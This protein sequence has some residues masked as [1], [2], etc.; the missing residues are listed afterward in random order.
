MRRVKALALCLAGAWFTAAPAPSARAQDCAVP[1]VDTTSGAVCGIAAAAA[2]RVR[3]Y[4]GIP[5]GQSTAG[6]NRWAPPRTVK[7]SSATLDA[8]T[9]GPICPQAQAQAGG[10]PMSEDCLSLN[11]WSPAAG[12]GDKLPVMVFLHGG[13][14]VIGSSRNPLYQAGKLAAHGQVV[15]VSLNYRLGALGFLA[16]LE[17]LAGNYGLL[18]QR[19]AL[20]WVRDNIAGFG[21]D[22][23]KVTLFGESAGA[24]SV[25]LH[26]ISPESAPLFRAAIMESNPYGIPYKTPKQAERLAVL[27]RDSLACE[28]GGI[29]CMRTRPFKAIVANQKSAL[30]KLQGVLSGL[31]GFLHWAPVLD[32]TL[33]PAQPAASPIAK[34]AIIGTNRDE[35]VLFATATGAKSL[36]KLE[37]ELALTLLFP[38]KAVREIK[39]LGRYKPARGDNTQALARLI[40]DFLFTCPSRRVMAQADSPVFGYQ[41]AQVPSYDM[42][43]QIPLCAPDQAKVCHAFELPFVFGNATTIVEQPQPAAHEFTP[44]EQALSERMMTAWTSF[45]TTLNPGADWPPFSPSQ[46]TRLIL[47]SPTSKKTDLGANCAFWG[48]LGDPQSGI[49]RQLP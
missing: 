32:G 28:A 17:G 14:F 42:W 27:L 9:F 21:G 40:T 43:P 16:G 39:Q 23:A 46:P 45:A 34:P 22:P 20:Q 2:P 8:S 1:V 44:A 30:L 6:D 15:V 4:L 38:L 31:S 19:L 13:A 5:Y 12:A 47:A 25:G 36:S 11:V 41:F 37:Y 49:L 18:D 26:L 7:E 29:A 24:M 35:G 10:Q 33:V 3:A 48:S